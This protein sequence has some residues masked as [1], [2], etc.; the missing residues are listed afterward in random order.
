MVADHQHGA[1]R[2]SA[3]RTARRAGIA[4]HDGEP[5]AGALPRHRGMRSA[6]DRLAEI[7]G[8]EPSFTDYW[9]RETIVSDETKRALRATMV[10]T[11]V[12]AGQTP[13]RERMRSVR[14]T[15]GSAVIFPRR[16]RRGAF[17]Y[18][19]RSCTGFVPRVTGESAISRICAPSHD[20]QR[21][22]VRAAS[23]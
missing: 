9:G 14:P 10:S 11:L 2:F 3:A 18:W 5:L 8:I 17:G 13:R 15:N 19:R 12:K 20:W 6:L 1:R 16:W 23:A 21:A 4:V 7:A 22:P